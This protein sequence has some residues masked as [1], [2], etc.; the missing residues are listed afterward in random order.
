[1][2]DC[3]TNSVKRI[4]YIIFVALFALALVPNGVLAA[5][6]G[7]TG[8][9]PASFA[10][11]ADSVKH[12]VVNIST[13]MVV[14]GEQF[15]GLSGHNAPFG[16]FFGDDF[17]KHF[18]GNMPRGEMK[19]HALGSGFVISPDGFIIT[20]NHVVDRATEIKVKLDNGKEY[21]AKIVGRDKKTDLALIKVKPDSNFPKP[22][23]LGDS[24][25]IRVG[26]WVMA[27]GNPFGL[28]QTVTTGIISA[29]GRVIGAGPY[30]DFLQ[31]DAAINPGNSG[32]PLFNM[33]GQVI[34]INTAIIAQGQNIGFA[35]PINIAKELL[36]QLKKGKIIR[37]W[38]GVMI[39]DITPELAKSFGLNSK[40]GVLISD[41]MKDSPAEKGGLLRGDVVIRFDG[42]E[43][44]DAHELS[45]I[46]A[47]TQPKTQATLDIIRDKKAKSL[48]I[49]IGT[50]P[51]N[52]KAGGLPADTSVWGLT[53]QEITPDL[54]RHLGLDPDE[55][56]V[57]ISG[58]E[59]GSPA[60]EAG[61]RAGDVIKEVNRN[62]VK[63]LGD[64]KKAMGKAKK[65][66][67]VLL[68]VKRGQGTLYVILNPP[69]KK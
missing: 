67:G 69:S 44:K 3:I 33:K 15:Q 53:V 16:R 64:Y 39:Q 12:A 50:M 1:M 65:E 58:L 54:A 47:E 5:S 26:D 35:I 48:K 57:V 41:V 34:G 11:L 49:E 30:D 20:N 8:K 29:K 40:K 60:V 63:D 46:V 61:L 25:A 23:A 22:V 55:K 2:K 68:L 32:G 51:Q 4:G 36:P 31:T 27:V 10:D 14:K 21:D 43:V 13:T 6:S 42:K 19:T 56:G 28:G 37:G 9:I 38:L 17:F 59:P 7:P 62:A 45:R 18:F 24:D 66:D 52:L